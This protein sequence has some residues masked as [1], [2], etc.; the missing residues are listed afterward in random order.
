MKRINTASKKQAIESFTSYDIAI[1]GAGNVAT[2]LAGYLQKS[3]HRISFIYSRSKSSA[4]G[5][6]N[7][8]GTRGSSMVEE[9]PET[10][11][12]FIVS[13]PDRAVPEVLREFKDY[14][15]IWL[16]TA[17]ALSC[18]VFAG[19]HNEFGVLYPL[20]TLNQ[21]RPISL[22]ESPFLIEGSSPE[23]TGKI[24][25]LASSISSFVQETDSPTRLRIHLAAVFA[26][27]FSNHMVH[28][29]QQMLRE[30]GVDLKLLDPILK[31]TFSKIAD[32]GAEASQTGPSMRDDRETMQKHLELLME[33]PEWGKLYTFISRDIKKSRKQNP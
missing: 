8:I 13:V 5:L 22:N 30:Q 23:V 21:K 4:T 12:F 27:N 18:D 28:I 15:G 7:M 25:S 24:R 32:M 1:L 2:H 11:D 16:H 19:L 33:H 3:G 31:E 20:Q 29:A 14:K 17:G 26:N 10:A 6:A 9:L